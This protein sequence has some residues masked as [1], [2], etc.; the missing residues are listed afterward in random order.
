M[1]TAKSILFQ[2]I[3]RKGSL[4][5]LVLLIASI[6]LISGLLGYVHMTAGSSD[7]IPIAPSSVVMFIT[8]SVL[9]LINIKLRKS[10]LTSSLVTLFVSINVIYCSIIFFQYI[11]NLNWDIEY[12][13]VKNPQSF[14]NVFIGRMSPISSLLFILIGMGILGNRQ[15][16][17]NTLKYIGG[18]FSLLVFLS[19]SVILIGYFYKVPLLYGS[20][21]IPVSLPASICFLLFSI[22]LLGLYE[23]KFWTFNMLKDRAVTIQLL[24]S[25]L[26]IVVFAVIIQGYVD[27]TFQ[28]HDKY[29]ALSVTTILLL[30]ITIIVFVVTKVSG[31]IGDKLHR[32]EQKLK[33]SESKYR[34]IVDNA[35]DG[36]GFGC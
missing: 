6:S 19:S 9:S 5:F 34:T 1:R 26:P 12:I 25:F 29:P 31:I 7:Y 15:K 30:F 32:T 14:G 36:I 13:L 35:G 24:K 18:S 17:S 11:F 23:L 2:L 10:P 33:E 22:A 3:K 21:I 8:L 28:V 4:L 16:N 27:V 20:K